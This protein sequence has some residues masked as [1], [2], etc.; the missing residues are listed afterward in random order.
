LDSDQKKTRNFQRE[1]TFGSNEGQLFIDP[2]TNNY[3]TSEE[4]HA[5]I[6][7]SDFMEARTVEL[8]EIMMNF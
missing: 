5:K 8:F 4:K 3:L 6:I 2:K 1:C 7:I